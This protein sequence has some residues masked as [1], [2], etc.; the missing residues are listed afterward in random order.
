M[1]EDRPWVK[2][3]KLVVFG[4]DVGRVGGESFIYSL[5][6]RRIRVRGLLVKHAVYGYEVI[7]S[8]RSMITDVTA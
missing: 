3:L 8:E 2:G 6:G 5:R 7:V 1:L 4:N